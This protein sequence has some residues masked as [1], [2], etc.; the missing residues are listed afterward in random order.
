[1][2]SKIDFLFYCPDLETSLALDKTESMHAVK[3]LRKKANDIIQV[4]DGKGGWFTCEIIRPDLKQCGLRI[5]ETTFEYNKPER[6]IFVAIAPTKNSDR[7]EY[8]L[9]KSTEIGI[10]G[11]YMLKTKNTVA[12]RINHERLEKITVSAMKQSLK[13]YKPFVSELIDFKTFLKEI[14]SFDQKLLAH[15]TDD[16]IDISEINLSKKILVC[17]GP[18]G[19]FSEEELD[20]AYKNGFENIT[21]GKNRLRTETAGVF[22][23]SVLNSRI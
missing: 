20:L 7:I 21:L 3:V 6:E 23:V 11:V 17:I 14:N 8:F 10:S 13:V 15:F 22:A 16:S 12:K 19:D 18:E 5:L 9:E 4:T 2:A 1:M